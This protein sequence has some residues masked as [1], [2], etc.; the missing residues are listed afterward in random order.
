LI[1]ASRDTVVR[2]ITSLRS[3]GFIATARRRITILDIDALRRYA[4]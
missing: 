1:A 3:L 2:A 4:E